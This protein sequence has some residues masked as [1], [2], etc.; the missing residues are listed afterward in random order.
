MAIG[1]PLSLIVVNL[2]METFKGKAL[3]TA[4][5][6]PKMWLRYVDDT[7]VFWPHNREQLQEFHDHLNTQHPDIQFTRKDESNRK[8]AFLDTL[9]DRKHTKIIHLFSETNQH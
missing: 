7:F 6:Q 8:T 3:R 9:V 4:T 1:S 2:Y 5:P